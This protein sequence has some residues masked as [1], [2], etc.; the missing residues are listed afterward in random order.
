M[1]KLPEK[2][3]PYS[4]IIYFVIIL[5]LSHFFWKFFVVGDEVEVDSFVTLFGIDISR[6]FTWLAQHIAHVVTA[7][8]NFLGFDV[9]LEPNNIVRHENGRAIRVVYSCTGIKQ[10]YI[11]CCIIAFY[12][13]PWLKKLWY[14]PLGLVIIHLFN[15]FR[16]AS[17]AGFIKN[18][19]ASFDFLHE[20]LF[21][22]MFYGI[23]FLMW[24][25]WEEKIVLKKQLKPKEENIS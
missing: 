10:A 22:Y 8:L 21:K 23:I 13:G 3:K 1:L 17:I 2:I 7:S 24:V 11:F 15:I 12:R 6:P 14:I 16:I 19:P 5:V 9:A 18:Y 20:H 25:F 4:G